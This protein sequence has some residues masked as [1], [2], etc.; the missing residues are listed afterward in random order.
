MLDGSHA[1]EHDRQNDSIPMHR[2]NLHT[3]IKNVFELRTLG[4]HCTTQPDAARR[5]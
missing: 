5:S 1:A 3:G 2:S 4:H